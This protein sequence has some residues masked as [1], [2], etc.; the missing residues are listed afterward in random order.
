MLFC[1][2]ESKHALRRNVQSCP[3]ELTP[4]P[5]GVGL[6]WRW[7]PSRRPSLTGLVRRA[8]RLPRS[9]ASP[10]RL[11][12]LS[13]SAASSCAPAAEREAES[14]ARKKQVATRAPRPPLRSSKLQAPGEP[15]GLGSASPL[16]PRVV[17]M[18][19]KFTCERQTDESRRRGD[20]QQ[21]S[22]SFT[23]GLQARHQP[24]SSPALEPGKAAPDPF[25]LRLRCKIY[26]FNVIMS[27]LQLAGEDKI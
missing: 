7:Q 26:G 19:L 21:P 23:P 25:M 9:S 8:C 11:R 18:S 14:H 6:L 3:S 2:P 15:G 27:R 1:K 17:F 20:R 16:H 12:L 22:P 13:S 5:S 24:I 10:A 4:R